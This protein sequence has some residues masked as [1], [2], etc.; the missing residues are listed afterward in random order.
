MDYLVTGINVLLIIVGFGI[1]IFVHELGHFVPAKWPVLPTD[2]FALRIGPVVAAWRRGIGVT[3]GSTHQ[4]VVARTGHAP[5]DLTDKQLA[6]HG[7][8]ETEYSLRWLPIGGF[9]RMLGQ[10]DL[11]PDRIAHDPPRYNPC[12]I[13]ARTGLGHARRTSRA[14]AWR[15]WACRARDVYLPLDSFAGTQTGG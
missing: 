10:G 12:P 7:I 5:G 13:G 9:V 11:H 14:Q 4:R 2:A 6:E 3:L 15:S 1:L 8:G